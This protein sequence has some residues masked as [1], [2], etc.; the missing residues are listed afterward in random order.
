MAF[1]YLHSNENMPKLGETI[2]VRL[3]DFIRECINRDSLAKFYKGDF[4][5]D[6]ES[7]IETGKGC[8]IVKP[9]E[10]GTYY[11]NCTAKDLDK[12][13][14]ASIRYIR[15]SL[16]WRNKTF[17]VFEVLVMESTGFE[18]SILETRA[19][20]TLFEGKIDQD[21]ILTLSTEESKKEGN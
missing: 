3:L 19:D 16:D 18:Q 1:P 17:P 11:A 20:V 2:N 4:L 7:I 5:L 10:C 21:S 6:F 13:Q 12:Y 9:S 14:G 8:I 15:Q